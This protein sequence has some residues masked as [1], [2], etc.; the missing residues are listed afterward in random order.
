MRKIYNLV[1]KCSIYALVFLMP[2]FWL[3][4][5]VEMFEFNKQYLLFVLTVLA[6]LAWI[7]KMVI[8]R[9]K[10]V[11]RRTPLDIWILVFMLVAVLSALFSIDRTSS[12]LGFY[13]RFSDS[14]IGLLA[15]CV[16][17]FVVVNNVRLGKGK[18]FSALPQDGGAVGAEKV[19][20]GA[21][22]GESAKAFSC[23]GVLSKFSGI[24][25]WG[26]SANKIVELLLVSGGIAVAAAYFS[27]FN[28][29]SK[30]PGLPSVM[31]LRSFNPF[32]G[33]LEGFSIFLAALIGLITGIFLQGKKRG[34][35]AKIFSYLLLTAA[36]ILLVIINFWAAWISLGI[37]MALL[38]AIAFWTRLFRK[39]VNILMLPIVLLIISGI[40]IV[41]LPGRVDLLND[42]SALNRNLPKE[43][44]LNSNVANIV[45]WQ[46]LKAEPIIG[47]GQGTFLANFAKFKPVEFNESEFWNVRFDKGSNYL[48]E[49]A[50]TM[51]ILGIL[52]YLTVVLMFLLIMFLSLWR[53]KKSKVAAGAKSR[54]AGGDKLIIL[55]FLLL[56]LILF[57]SQFVYSQNTALLFYFWLFTALGIVSWQ[58]VQDAPCKKISFSFKKLP[59]VGLVVNV[60]LLIL[61]FTAAGLFYVGGRF[62]LAE[63]K[64]AQAV[65]DS[66]E[67]VN[68]AEEI[69]NLNRY[70]ANYRQNL[71]QVYLISAWEEARKPEEERNAQLLQALAAGSIQQAKIAADI[72]PNSVS[73]WENLGAVYRNARG[74]IG[75]T[76]PFA[77]EAYA[78]AVE[79][80]PSNPFFYRELCRLRLTTEGEEERTEEQWNETVSYCQKAV[81]LK[82][83]YLDA[84]IQ[85]A[86]VYEQKGDLERALEQMNSIMAKLKGVSFQRDSELAGAATEIYFQTGRLY[87]NLERIDEAIKMFEQAVIITPQYANGRYALALSYQSVGRTDDALIQFKFVDQLVPGNENIE[88]IIEQLEG[89]SE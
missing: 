47:S 52:S 20:L 44:V 5:T 30:I 25:S 11:F 31:G 21:S 61:V 6:F 35:L 72:S 15:M 57:I 50:G 38:L 53:L 85:L 46:S 16:M 12:W 75:G 70:R 19:S 8:V 39:K 28:V 26:V 10:V 69:V 60:V 58:G 84:H 54:L 56:W 42:F 18:D 65:T 82:S 17:Y 4:W 41:N 87:F 7:A 62:Y 59:E 2:L 76:L 83:D 45:A 49:M 1:I 51:G 64:S 23:K 29:W 48:I 68:R 14:A 40:F 67:L 36:I 78:K 33:S 80:E 27:I 77:L 9:K 63:V 71:S 79:L 74:L 81:D 88:G 13:G 22:F 34:K 24:G 43:L 3:P 86:L 32:G 55:P 37:A 89:V 73:A 66:Q